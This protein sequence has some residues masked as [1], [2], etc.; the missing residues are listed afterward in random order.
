[1]EIAV[2]AP[3]IITARTQA[4]M[5]GAMVPG[6]KGRRELSRMLS[7]KPLAAAEAMAAAQGALV[8]QSVDLWSGASKIGGLFWFDLA[9]DVLSASL[10][11]ISRRVRGNSRRLT[12]G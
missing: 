11:P 3:A 2:L 12:R 7:E 10:A 1:M 4:M 9:E 5:L 6:R 8:K